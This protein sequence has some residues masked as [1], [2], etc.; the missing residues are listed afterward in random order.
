MNTSSSSSDFEE[1]C[2]A[3]IAA[4][5]QACVNRASTPI[6]IKPPSNI[7]LLWFFEKHDV[8]PTKDCLS[9]GY[10]YSTDTFNGHDCPHQGVCECGLIYCTTCRILIIGDVAKEFVNKDLWDKCI[11]CLVN[12]E[13]DKFG[14]AFKKTFYEKY[15]LED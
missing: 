10:N 9:C 8:D 11:Q 13:Q 2:D 15:M 4:Y 5:A 3:M 12:D 14:G 7:P 1:E 6:E